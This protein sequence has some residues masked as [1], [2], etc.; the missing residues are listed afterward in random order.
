MPQEILKTLEEWI[1]PKHTALV[2]I[3]PQND[4]CASDGAAAR[5]MGT[6]VSRIQKAVQPLNAF[7]ETARKA[8]LMIVWTR[9][10]VDLNKTRPSFRARSFM[11]DENV[12][13]IKVVREG[14]DGADW[15]SEVVKPLPDEHIITKYHYDAFE[16]TDLDLLL[17]WHQIK[18]LLMTGFLANV[19]VE[20]TARHGYI[21]GYYIVAVS[22]CTDTAT[23][24]EQE[25][26]L[27]NIKK[28]FGKV[29][30]SDE[31][32]KAWGQ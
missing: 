15:Y 3:D 6:D 8:G 22:D 29:A 9:S 12:R 30:T 26:T 4:F 27:Y 14:S 7:I 13:N 16:D 1:D 19:C 10:L 18:T 2:V 21:K 20:T 24:Q 17:G 32:K 25:A 23:E 28:Y 5:L 31:I 11:L